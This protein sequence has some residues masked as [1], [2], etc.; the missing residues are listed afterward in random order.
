MQ[1]LHFSTVERLLLKGR[2]GSV[3]SFTVH[4]LMIAR[5]LVFALFHIGREHCKVVAAAFTRWRRRA[6]VFLHRCFHKLIARKLT[7]VIY[8]LFATLTIKF[9]SITAS[10]FNILQISPVISGGLDV[11]L[12][13]LVVALIYLVGAIV[14]PL[15]RM[16]RHNNEDILKFGDDFS[17]LLSLRSAIEGS[18][19]AFALWDKNRK[20]LVSN[21]KFKE[22]YNIQDEWADSTGPDYHQFVSEI[23]KLMMRAPRM[24][25]SFKA[26]H[27]QTQMRDG[28]WLNIQEQPTVE[29]GLLCVSFDVTKLKTVQ[30]NLIIREQQMRSTVETL[31]TSRRELERKTQKLA[32]LADKYMNEKERAEEANQVKSEF[33]AN[34]SHELRTPLNAI[35]GFSDMMQR[36]VLGAIDNPKY[37]SYISDIHMSG[38][39]LLELINDILDMSRIEAGRLQ[40]D[41]KKCSLNKLL[42]ECTH[43]VSAQANQ[44]QINLQQ[45][46]DD[47]IFCTIDQRAIKQVLLNLMSNAIKFTPSGGR[48]EVIIKRRADEV[49]IYVKDSGIGIER[50]QLSLLGR[51]FVQVENQM[52]KSYS[53]TGLGLA[54]SRSLVDLHQ[55]SLTIE[56]EVGVGTCVCVSLPLTPSVFDE[57]KSA[58][59]S[60]A[61]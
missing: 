7:L 8:G 59:S 31:R 51:P 1:I 30:Q 47:E 44:Q 26:A 15:I 42:D 2:L 35:I 27:Y 43:L 12:I 28:R 9:I 33:L 53:G 24:A 52:T 57:G 23:N 41:T 36:E 45:T 40:L 20:L 4:C 5:S 22:I 34:I 13:F 21:A 60:M 14:H 19:E 39:Y 49:C 25:K 17:K 55:G 54:I 48:V 50:S 46:Y 29:G 56:S 11:V 61:A 58:F 16:E 32:E 6:L 10:V 37:Q 3:F 38:S 18:P